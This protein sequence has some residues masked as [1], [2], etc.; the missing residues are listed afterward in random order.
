M[1]YNGYNLNNPDFPNDPSRKNAGYGIS[2]R[3]D[4]DSEFNLS[5]GVDCKVKFINNSR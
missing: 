4:L 2:S 3:Y 5:G 1:R